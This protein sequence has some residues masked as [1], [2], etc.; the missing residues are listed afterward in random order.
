MSLTSSHT[1][2]SGGSS[3]AGSS[4]PSLPSVSA[5]VRSVEKDALGELAQLNFPEGSP[6]DD[7]GAEAGGS[8]GSDMDADGIEQ[9]FLMARTFFERASA[10]GH[11]EA[12]AR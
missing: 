1:S 3:D 2:C 11:A 12:T 6:G 10:C 4:T 8:D 9:N 7:G 5:T